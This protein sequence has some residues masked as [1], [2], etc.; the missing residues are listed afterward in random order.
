MEGGRPVV[1]FPEGRITTTGSLMKTYDGP[2]FV[3]RQDRR[4]H[5]S[6]AHRRAARTYFSARGPRSTRLFPRI[7]LS[8]LPTTRIPMPETARPAIGGAG[9]GRRCGA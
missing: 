6:G 3:A 8:L 4:H 5:P 1:I 2:A 7:S 9:R